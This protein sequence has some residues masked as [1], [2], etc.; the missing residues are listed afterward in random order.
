METTRKLIKW[1]SSNT[2]IISLPRKWI[3]QNSLSADQ[4]VQI[5]TNPDGT[6]TIVPKGIS[7]NQIL[8]DSTVKIKDPY[9]MD[10]IRFRILTKYLDGCD[11]INLESAN[12]FPSDIRLKIEEIIEPLLGLEIFGISKNQLVIKNVMSV[13]ASNVFNLIKMISDLT[14]ELSKI[15]PK[16][17]NHE[18][19][20]DKDLGAI[21]W[22]NINKYHYR[23]TREQRK[24]LL[25]PAILSKMQINL[26]DVLD[27]AFY[28]NDLSK[29]A[30]G[31]KFIID[32]IIKNGIPADEFGIY[33]FFYEVIQIIK[34]S[35]NSFL[36]KESKKSIEILKQIKN[37]KP[38]KREIENK[39]DLN[40]AQCSDNKP[41]LLS[42]QIL[43]DFSEKILDYCDSICLAALRRAI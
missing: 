12:E 18:I 33:K 30:E 27:F 35:I 20:V 31:L 9:D 41:K 3:K 40:E 4:V 23:I 16:L 10:N 43:L 28:V 2:L 13:D 6:L 39:V 14:I 15:I 21:E 1:G 34:D 42:F 38:K 29:I 19:E 24:A 5:K 25:H 26:Q 7:K 36:F 32:S 22:E 37:I 17:L 11:I 8:I